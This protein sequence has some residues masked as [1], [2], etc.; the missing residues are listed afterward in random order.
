VSRCGQKG[1]ADRGLAEIKGS[2]MTAGLCELA[3]LVGCSWSY[4]TAAGVLK[5]LRGVQFS[6]EHV[7]HLTNE[8][9]KALASQQHEQAW[10]I[11]KG[12]VGLQRMRSQHGQ[13]DGGMPSGITREAWRARSGWW[14]VTSS[15]WA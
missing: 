12:A 7:R 2:N 5:R 11:L 10:Q 9:G 6:A 15:R 3:A 4:E 13:E 1:P 14:P 8:Q